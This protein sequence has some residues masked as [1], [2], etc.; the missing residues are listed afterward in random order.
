[1]GAETFQTSLITLGESKTCASTHF[2]GS[3]G[4]SLNL[5]VA[6]ETA[7]EYSLFPPVAKGE[8]RV[9]SSSFLSF[10]FVNANTAG[11]QL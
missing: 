9:I 10:C 6:L 3:D 5:S 2:E 7:C 4:F 8:K 11:N 1:M